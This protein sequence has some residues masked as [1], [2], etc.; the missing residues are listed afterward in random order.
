MYNP[1]VGDP[2]APPD[3]DSFGSWKSLQQDLRN[4]WR[5]V[6]K[7]F[8]N[9]FILFHLTIAGLCI[10]PFFPLRNKLV[11]PTTPYTR[12]TG[13]EQYWGIFAP[14]V[15]T[16]DW[17]LDATIVFQDGNRTMWQFP[18]ASRMSLVKRSLRA[19]QFVWSWVL[20]SLPPAWPDAARYVARLHAD[21]HNPPRQIVLTWWSA[22]I[23]PP[24]GRAYLPLSKGY[25]HDQPD[26]SPRVLTT[27]DVTP[28]DL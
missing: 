25:A 9:A 11:A 14:N 5:D 17:H 20:A 26:V 1:L 27:Y 21:P 13:L 12:I 10:L 4:L 16:D 18:R 24:Q 19:R 3:S 22:P 15:P 6:R 8:L 23:T 7:P 2:S 28:Q